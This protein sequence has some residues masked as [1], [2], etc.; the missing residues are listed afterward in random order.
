M[1]KEKF[2]EKAKAQAVL[3]KT[4]L[5]QIVEKLL[6]KI[7]SRCLLNGLSAARSTIINVIVRTTTTTSP[8]T[9][10]LRSTNLNMR[11]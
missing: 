11:I 10:N 3:R 4:S 2:V 7:G 8:M 1:A 9:S 6:G 5:S